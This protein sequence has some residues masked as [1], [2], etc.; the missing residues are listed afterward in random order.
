ML[1]SEHYKQLIIDGIHQLPPIALME[2]VDFINFIKQ[3]NTQIFSLDLS[4]NIISESQ[5][6]SESE[7]SHLEEEFKDYAQRFPHN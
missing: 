5:L 2:I 3:K 6:M 1:S 7:T 4:K